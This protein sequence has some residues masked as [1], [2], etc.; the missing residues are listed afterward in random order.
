[1]ADLTIESSQPLPQDGG[2]SIVSSAPL[3]SGGGGFWSNLIDQIHP[4]EMAKGLY[5]TVTHPVDALQSWQ[6]QSQAL[7]DKAEQA[8][9]EG[10]YVD[11][12][13]HGINFLANI[14][15]GL[16]KAMDDAAEGIANAKSDEEVRANLGKLTGQVLPLAA[17]GIIKGSAEAV[18]PA[19][20]AGRDLAADAL[21]SSAEKQYARVLNATTKGNKARSAEVAPGLL[22]RGVVAPTLSG[23]QGKIS[24]QIQ[25]FGRQ[26]GDA[27]D[28][29][30]D[31]A[32]IPLSDIQGR[33]MKAAN[34]SFTVTPPEGSAAAGA[35]PTPGPLA[36][37]GV[38][39]AQELASRI[40][41]YAVKDASGNLVV[42]ARTARE[43]RQ[44]Y[45]H[46]AAQ[47]GRYDAKTLA[48]HSIAEAH[49]MAADAIRHVLAEQY[50]DIAEL[51]REYSFWKDA[52]RV[53]SDTLLRRQ[54]QAVPLGQKLL[55]GAGVAGG[56]AAGGIHGGIIGGAVMNTL[57]K[58]IDSTGWNTVSAVAKSKLA[59]AIAFDD[60]PGI[61]LAAHEIQQQ[62]EQQQPEAIPAAEAPT[63][64]KTTEAVPAPPQP[65]TEGLPKPEA[66]DIV[67]TDGGNG[68]QGNQGQGSA[69]QEPSG[70]SQEVAD[71]TQTRVRVPGENTSY[72]ANYQVRELSDVQP[73][74][75]GVTFQP[76]PKYA[77]K[78]DRDYSNP[79]NQG[80][81]VSWSSPKE[82][83]PTYH[84]TDN[85]DATNGPVV[86]DSEGH[87]LGGN[88]RTMILQRVYANNPGGAQ[89]YKNLLIQKAPQFGLDPEVIKGMNQ[90]VL[91]R[92]IADSEF[93]EPSGSKQNAITDFNKTGTAELTPAERAVADSRRVSA[94]TLNHIGSLLDDAGPEATLTK[95]LEGK[96]GT[97]VLN[98]LI[99]DGVVSP[100]ERAAYAS[101]N[102]LTKDGQTRI[103]KL[104]LGRFFRDPAQ[105]DA[106]AP[107]IRNKMERV[108]APLAGVEGSEWDITPKV[109]E[110]MDLIEEA[111]AH[112]TKNLD[113][114]M[115]QGGLFM[116]QKYSPESVTLAKAFQNGK[117]ADL[118]GAVK[119]YY[120]DAAYAKAGPSLFGEP[121][122]PKSSFDESF[123]KI[124]NRG[125]RPAVGDTVTLNGVGP[126]VIKKIN[127]NGT[128]DY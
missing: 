127:P 50:P 64:P 97:E 89:A 117:Q 98:R 79:E 110:A 65:I 46:I 20:S 84:I 116:E 32:S 54:G 70:A 23:L 16:G 90:P 113:D 15:P 29:L 10:R 126:V 21:R 30:P 8:M 34:D 124:I 7:K 106:I 107:S 123:G 93:E 128:F 68:G 78:N 38:A 66:S 85:P 53:V 91:V 26:I 115:K 25:N 14:V 49:G 104:L 48:D 43:L 118:I 77:I 19:V 100:Q 76:N 109:Q 45:D 112:G 11:A 75:S 17:P 87:A 125:N 47:A 42:P 1:M 22:D 99:D 31:D 61:A 27:F 101:G 63:A 36:D 92:Q 105:V 81:V 40:G 9:N 96:S 6:S 62:L 60:G 12:A 83:D 18:S 108:A 71:P 88:G 3:S 28:G 57:Q 59:N 119:Q 13:A 41:D 82:F 56:V 37:T 69:V 4:V 58:L 86:V 95:V 33:I 103:S 80:K 5:Q 114:F 24:S 74:H 122:N 102:T 35:T 120:E 55:K 73:S 39:H 52:G 51:N 111:N 72:K 67:E 44:Y 94:D 2:L 121:P